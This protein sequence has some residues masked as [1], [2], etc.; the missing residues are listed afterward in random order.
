MAHEDGYVDIVSGLLVEIPLTWVKIR[1]QQHLM[2]D[3]SLNCWSQPAPLL[4]PLSPDSPRDNYYQETP[5]TLQIYLSTYK[6][7]ATQ[8][9]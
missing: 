7:L 4:Q 2:A 5:W 9:L 8:G 6:Q 3:L 1:K